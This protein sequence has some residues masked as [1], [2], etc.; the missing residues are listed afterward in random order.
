M[1]G[2]QQAVGGGNPIGPAVDHLST[3][4]F[5]III[6]PV[7]LDQPCS[8]QHTVHIVVQAAV[9][10]DNA[11][12][13]FRLLRISGG[14]RLLNLPAVWGIDH[15]SGLVKSV[16]ARRQQVVGNCNPIG[17]VFDGC[18]GAGSEV[19]IISIHLNQSNA[20]NPAA[21]FNQIDLTGFIGIQSG[22]VLLPYSSLLIE[23]EVSHLCIAAVFVNLGVK[24]GH[25]IS[26][27]RFPRIILVSVNLNPAVHNPFPSPFVMV[28]FFRFNQVAPGQDIVCEC[29]VVTCNALLTVHSF[30]GGR[31]KII[32]LICPVH[33]QHT[34]TRGL[35][36]VDGI[37]QSS[38]QLKQPSYPALAYAVFTK[39][40][41]ILVVSVLIIRR[42]VNSG[43]R[44]V[45]HKVVEIISRPL[46]ALPN[47]AVQSK[48]VLKGGVCRAKMSTTLA[49]VI[50]IDEGIQIICL[51]NTFTCGYIIECTG[52]QIDIIAHCTCVGNRQTATIIP[53]CIF[54]GGGFDTAQ[55]TDGVGRC[56][57]NGLSLVNP[58][59]NDRQS[60]GILIIALRGHGEVL[61][62]QRHLA[63]IK[64][65]I[66]IHLK[67][68]FYFGQ[69][70]DP[71]RQLQQ[72]I[73]RCGISRIS[74]GEQRD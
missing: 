15:F 25:K 29:I 31:V 18:S 16:L 74:A 70:T 51:L 5:D 69:N 72:E 46:P 68:H 7:Q 22:V 73:P 48:A 40:V 6:V 27:G 37:I 61:I 52:A 56:R 67:L 54:F 2:G 21:V 41:V 43:H 50:G 33:S 35:H 66:R 28:T 30:A 55:D 4:G 64:C 44:R 49:G 60:M 8:G 20:A 58:V 36:A 45:I 63:E 47:G 11:V 42:Q 3:G 23:Q 26:I 14:I 1:G 34:P 17:S 38:V 65:E 24:I 62:Y 59:A 71:L 57:I 9:F 13:D 32:V 53:S 19:E 39:P 12:F 10:R